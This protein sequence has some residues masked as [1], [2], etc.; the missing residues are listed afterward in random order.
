MGDQRALRHAVAV[1]IVDPHHLE[2]LELLLDAVGDGEVRHRGP[3]VDRNEVGGEAGHPGL[4]IVH[5]GKL[6]APGGKGK[7]PAMQPTDLRYL[8]PRSGRT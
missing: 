5:G 4:D 8:D 6:A 1:G 3:A 2:A 7:S